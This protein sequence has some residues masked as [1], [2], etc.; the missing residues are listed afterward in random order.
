[1][2]PS[3]PAGDGN[4]VAKTGA[5]FEENSAPQKIVVNTRP[6]AVK[7]EF[8]G[9]TQTS[10]VDSGHITDE[11]GNPL[12]EPRTAEVKPDITAEQAKPDKPKTDEGEMVN[13]LAK[14]AAD[15]KAAGE[16]TTKAN[17]QVQALVESKT[18]FV[19]V[20]KVAKRRKTAVFVIALVLVLAVG[21]VAYL[22]LA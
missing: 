16:A 8:T 20:G 3:E 10:E 6:R 14:A 21:A 1:M 2:A 12:K 9:G 4:S 15:K 7:P 13:E 5:E 11:P 22:M 18:Y 17:A 19:P